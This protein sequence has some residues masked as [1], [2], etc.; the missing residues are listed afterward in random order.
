MSA[1]ILVVDDS[2]ITRK[3]IKNT[4]VKE[5]FEIES[6]EDG[7]EGLEK[8]YR[9]DFDLLLVDINMPNMGGAEFVE[10]VR[11]DSDYAS[12]PIIILT[13]VAREEVVKRVM[14]AGANLYIKK[15]PSE[16]E[17]L[18]GINNLLGK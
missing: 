17:L 18:S 10:N 4:L 12:L 13:S 9:G 16:K 11:K 7:M 6:A 3:I 8:L 1:K 5:S 14:N 2:P 15:P